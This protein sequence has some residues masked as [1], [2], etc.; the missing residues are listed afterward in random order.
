MN[1]GGTSPFLLIARWAP[2]ICDMDN[3][4]PFLA[5]SL[6]VGIFPDSFPIEV[7]C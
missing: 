7:A 4:L 3:G 2:G 6:V 1:F 5:V